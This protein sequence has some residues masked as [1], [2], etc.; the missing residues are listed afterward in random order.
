V[1][2]ERV[3]RFREAADY[4]ANAL[5]QHPEHIEPAAVGRAAGGCAR[6]LTEKICRL[7]TGVTDTCKRV[8]LNLCT[9]FRQSAKGEENPANHRLF[10][11]IPGCNGKPS[12]RINSPLLYQ[13][14][15][16]GSFKA[17]GGANKCGR[18]SE[19]MGQF[20][21]NSS[22]I[23]PLLKPPND[24][25]SP[26][27]WRVHSPLSFGRPV[28][29]VSSSS[30]EAALSAAYSHGCGR[31]RLPASED[32]DYM[33]EFLALLLFLT[34]VGLGFLTYFAIQL[35]TENARLATEHKQAQDSSVALKGQ[36]Q[37]LVS[38]YNENV[39]RWNELSTGFNAEIQRLAKW[40][41]VA[42]A[43]AIAVRMKQE[44]HVTLENAKADSATLV[45]TA[46]QQAAAILADASQKAM[47]ETTAAN[48]AAGA[49][50][51]EAK[52]ESKS[53]DKRVP[54]DSRIRHRTGRKDR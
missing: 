28:A 49:V 51:S 2:N 15:Y 32:G 54:S 29:E 18:S 43:D 38:K 16:R 23:K 50:V 1:S 30:L 26:A 36:Y 4:A 27:G 46:Q 34:V 7:A 5:V 3:S 37:T 17:S 53:A 48:N 21:R 44:A 45:L 14:S 39:K 10:S 35:R 31:I 40:K 41:N 25:L 22:A 11:T 8:F 13:L 24:V 33:P 52:T 6:Y 42:D 9:C 12:F 19:D 47:A 20:N